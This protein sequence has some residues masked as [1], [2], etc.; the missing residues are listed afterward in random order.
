MSETIDKK[1]YH[2]LYYE[3][4]KQKF[5]EWSSKK[6]FCE[7]CNKHITAPNMAPHLRTK[8]HLKNMEVK[9]K[10]NNIPKEKVYELLE[11]IIDKIKDKD[12]TNIKNQLRGI[13]NLLIN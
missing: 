13:N 11:V 2:K 5:K 9:I 10:D 8:T 4:N 1:T 7:C 6:I 12:F 3:K